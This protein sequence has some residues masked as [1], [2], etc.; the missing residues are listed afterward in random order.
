M[1]CPFCES[2]NYE[3]HFAVFSNLLPFI[4]LG[5]KYSPQHP[6]IKYCE[7]HSAVRAVRCTMLVTLVDSLYEYYV[8]TP[9]LSTAVVFNFFCVPVPNVI[10]L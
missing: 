1:P 4:L 7:M 5:P 9:A 6:A 2:I 8:R 10:S 3:A